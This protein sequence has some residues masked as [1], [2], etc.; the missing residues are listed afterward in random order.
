MLFP[1]NS[2][3][4][5]HTKPIYFYNPI[6]ITGER[7]R[8]SVCWSYTAHL[9]WA[10]LLLYPGYWWVWCLKYWLVPGVQGGEWVSVND[11]PEGCEYVCNSKWS[12]RDQMWSHMFSHVC[13]LTCLLSN[14]LPHEYYSNNYQR[15]SEYRVSNAQHLYCMIQESSTRAFMQAHVFAS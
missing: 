4:H 12:L 3:W 5:I 2:Y 7:T 9:P 11:T 10:N 14:V 1:N 15:S 13:V 8:V 6:R